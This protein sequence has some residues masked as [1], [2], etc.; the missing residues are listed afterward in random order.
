MSLLAVVSASIAPAAVVAQEDTRF[1]SCAPIAADGLRLACYDR[2]MALPATR[3]EAARRD[4]G[5]AKMEKAE[6]AAPI[7][8]APVTV[9]AAGHDQPKTVSSTLSALWETGQGDKRGTFA[10]RPYRENY[11]LLANYSPSPNEVPFQTNAGAT[12]LQHTELAFQISFKVKAL[13]D[14]PYTHS[15]LWFG[16]TQQNFW[17]A[18]NKAQSR[19]FRETNF[20]P[21]AMLVTPLGYNLGGG[22]RAEFLN[23]GVLHQSNGRGIAGSRSWNRLYAQV[24]LEKGDASVLVR[25][26][27]RLAE[28]GTDDNP[29]ITSFM[30]HGDVTANYRWRGHTFSALARRNFSTNKGAAQLS[31][32][33]PLK[34][35]LKGYVQAFS[36]YG[37]SLIDY[38]SNQKS[39]GAGFLVDF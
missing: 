2:L 8:A 31:W 21:E 36:G 10:L 9:I 39:I 12:D 30:G 24:G 32:A 19:P 5:E 20:Q 6:A 35:N 11:L 23:L 33:F 22:V 1:A 28:S 16:Y 26:W 7:A 38:N 14:L 29:D 13:E 25:M 18:Y 15:D 17:Q 34:D 27:K 4:A 3:A 37:Q